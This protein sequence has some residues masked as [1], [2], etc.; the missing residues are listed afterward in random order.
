MPLKA[1]EIWLLQAP[2][3]DADF[4]EL[5]IRRIIQD[6]EGFIWAASQNGLIKYDGYQF[7]TYYYDASNPTGLRHNFIT[8][9]LEDPEE[10]FI[11][12]TTYGGGLH[13]FDKR[14]N[15]I[16]WIPL[17]L[18]SKKSL[19]LNCLSITP[20][21]SLWLGGVDSL[22][23]IN[24]QT[25]K[26]ESVRFKPEKQAQPNI[27]SIQPIGKDKIWL[28][29]ADGI[30][31]FN[32][33]NKQSKQLSKTSGKSV[34]CIIA[35]N[36]PQLLIAGVNNEILVYDKKSN[37]YKFYNFNNPV[38]KSINTIAAISDDEYWLGTDNGLWKWQF[39]TNIITP[40]TLYDPIR[41]KSSSFNIQSIFKDNAGHWWIGTEYS[42]F[43]QLIP[44]YFKPF[45]QRVFPTT[46][47]RHP[48]VTT[49]YQTDDQLLWIGTMKGLQLYDLTKQE[50][51]TLKINKEEPLLNNRI[52]F[53]Y[54]DTKSQIW[55][56]VMNGGYYL[57]KSLEDFINLGKYEHFNFQDETGAIVTPNAAMRI[58]EDKYG[59]VWLGTFGNGVYIH[60]PKFND[61]D[62]FIQ[63][64]NADSLQLNSNTISS[65]VAD[66][67]HN[68]WIGT[69]DMGLFQYLTSDFEVPQNRFRSFLP[70][71]NNPNSL[72]HEIVLS[73][74]PDSKGFIWIGTYS[75]G[76]NRYDPK[77][78]EWRRYTQKDGLI[79]AIIYAILPDNEENLWLSTDIGLIQYKI[80]ENR[81]VHYSQQNGLPFNRHYFFSAY[82]N[83]TSGELFFGGSN[84]LYSFNPAELQDN[85][86]SPVCRIT[87]FKL[88][89]E[90]VPVSSES[91]L[92]ED[93]SYTS[94]LKL[95]YY[96]TALEFQL[97]A[98]SYRYPEQNQY[99]YQLEGFDP[100]WN[101]VGNKNEITYT[102]LDPGIYTLRYK[103][104]DYRGVW[105]EEGILKIRIMPPP[106]ASWWAYLI[107]IIIIVGII[108]TIYHFQLNR[109]LALAETVRLKELDV[110]KSRLYTNITHE[111]RTPLTIILGMARQVLDN[112]K[113][114]FRSG[115]DMIIR[116]GQNLLSLVNQMLDLSKLESGKMKLNV[117]QSDIISFLKYLLESFHSLAENKN[118]QLHFS[119]DYDTLIMD[120][121][122]ERLQQIISNLLSNAI[123][124][125]P[126]GGHVY[127]EVR[128]TN[129]E[130][131][132]T[133]VKTNVLPTSYLGL[134]VKDTGIGITEEDLPHIFERFYQADDS[135]TRKGEGTGIGLALT[136]ELVKLMQGDIQVKSKPGQGSEFIITLPIRQ[137]APEVV[138]PVL[139]KNITSVNKV[140]ISSTPEIVENQ[141]KP[142]ILIIEDNADVVS[143][144]VTCLQDH[145]QILIGSDG[146]QGVDLALHYI[147]DLIITDVMMPHKDG[148][149]VCQ[150]LKNDERSSHI[151]II[152]LTAKA[153]MA[154]KLEGLERGADDYLAKP[155][156][157][158]ELLIRVRKL[159]ELR[160][161]LQCY[162][163]A[164]AGLTEDTV[165]IKDIS[166]VDIKE[167]AFVKKVRQAVEEHLDDPEL[168][169]EKLCKKLIM[170]H[171]QLHRKLSALTGFSANT[172]IRYIR[173]NKAKELLRN[174]ALTI[175]SVAFDTGFNDPSYFGRVFKKEFGVTPQEWREQQRKEV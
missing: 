9:L 150:I 123:K 16:G 21:Q 134:C 106:W 41:E 78:N 104:A 99:A 173:L 23:K 171:S 59:N 2:G 141:S 5:Q 124:F 86:P 164:A 170:S 30:I 60:R 8:N 156:H 144:L 55:I 28:G 142:S 98:L 66:A 31:E 93:I 36:N 115:L 74:Y 152:M 69:Y 46:K 87:T 168:N 52:T 19:A 166:K 159:L 50:E 26:N 38:F 37:D 84:G 6:R 57:I 68:I 95:K 135:H 10:E 107:Y 76:L 51:I 169:V 83:P 3:K 92:K 118:I 71:P 62:L 94:S 47:L 64:P 65:I 81:F 54:K 40:I 117:G 13:R 61:I 148:F 96:Q 143:Y 149:E 174:Q 11:W 139:V 77:R 89:N 90:V 14:Q 127:L 175:T 151:P 100:D 34:R 44:E 131:R 167:N 45:P 67:E 29:T 72:S 163:L 79:S 7:Y 48:T 12:I 27:S 22:Y 113:D 91:I 109:Q 39:D 32:T 1:Q 140:N 101:Y 56:G 137:E 165:I 33:I 80:A 147:P 172:F 162:Y 128:N 18:K 70:D 43:W 42:G 63:N 111:F 119:S 58:L 132:F 158:D 120:Y 153:D 126:N 145:Y 108:Y 102:N 82:R 155:F 114:H 160:H 73:V 20:D 161:K 35:R 154:S 122:A 116:N 129:D 121:D 138:Q 49:I 24:R 136:K 25:L 53:I 112:P 75:G 4:Q 146:Q 17:K 133:K 97:A 157:K 15:K 85:A 125:T 130:V 103:A 105:S 88:S 110:V